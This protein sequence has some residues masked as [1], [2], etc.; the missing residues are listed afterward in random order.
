[1]NQLMLLTL[2]PLLAACRLEPVGEPWTEDTVTATSGTLPSGFVFQADGP[3]YVGALES[4]I[5]DAVSVIVGL[6]SSR[7]EMEKVLAGLTLTI[8]TKVECLATSGDGNS[9]TYARSTWGGDAS[10]WTPP[11]VV[12]NQR[13]TQLAHEFLHLLKAYRNE[14]GNADHSGWT[15]REWDTVDAAAA[16]A[17]RVTP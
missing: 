4:N 8:K 11:S 10:D 17:Y 7:E 6:G 14:A 12:L 1:M 15:S 5:Q 9:C 16:V 13:G 3:V 2:L